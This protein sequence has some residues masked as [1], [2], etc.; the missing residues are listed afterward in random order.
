MIIYNLFPLLVRAVPGVGASRR[1]GCRDGFGLAVRQPG[2]AAR[3]LGGHLFDQRTV[4]KFKPALIEPSDPRSG[5]DQ[6][7]S[8]LSLARDRGM[9]PMADLVIDHC[10][11]DSELVTE[12]PEWIA[13]DSDGGVTHP[14]CQEDGQ[15]V[16][17]T[18]LAQL[19][20]RHTRDPKELY[21]YCLGVVRHLLSLGFEGFRCDTAY[22][23]PA[24]LWRRLI[25]DTNNDRPGT[26]FVAETLGC[27]PWQTAMTAASQLR[28]HLQQ[29]EMVGFSG[30]LAPRTA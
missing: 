3:G 2:S 22:Q 6:L 21:Q 17:W 30:P 24:E 11:A 1:A 9:R 25:A 4:F 5:Q 20:H 15:T 10:A 14:S 28:L 18:N 23:L 8:V 12:H 27:R 26:V 7:R 13:F 29:R 19:D 16:V